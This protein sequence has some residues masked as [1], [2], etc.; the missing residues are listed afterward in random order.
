MPEAKIYDETC[1]RPCKIKKK[2]AGENF[3]GKLIYLKAIVY[4][5]KF[6]R[7]CLGPEQMICSKNVLEDPTL[8]HKSDL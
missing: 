5:E 2:K 3:S 8:S 1:T 4:M 7:L 6:K